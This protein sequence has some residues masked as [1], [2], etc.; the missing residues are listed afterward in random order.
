MKNTKSLVFV[1]FVLVF[2]LACGLSG[3]NLPTPAASVEPVAQPSDTPAP[4]STE[5][6][7]SPQSPESS[8]PTAP[9][10]NVPDEPVAVVHLL[11][12][13]DFSNDGVPNYDVE[14]NGTA[15]EKRAPFGDSY[16]MNLLERPFTND[17]TYIPELD[18][19][20][21]RATADET[22][23]Y[24]TIELIG[25][26]LN[27]ALGIHYGVVLDTDRNGYGDFLL[28]T[29]PPYAR[30]WTAVNVQVF[31]DLNGDSAGLS[32]LKSD[33]PFQ[34]DGY[35]TLIFDINQGIGDDADLAWVRQSGDGNLIQFAFKKELTGSQF[36]FSAIADAGLRDPGRMD[37]VDHMTEKEAGSPVRANANYPLK[38]LF[39]VDNTCQAAFGFVPTGF[40]PKGCPRIVPPTQQSSSGSGAEAT[41]GMSGCQP[42]PGGCTGDAP[43]WWP[44]PHCACSS[45]PYNP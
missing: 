17:M 8:L 44:D 43:H 16:N 25:N 20:V 42:P 5:S 33:A 28:W 30:D 37:Y 6:P 41:P 24:I 15:P 40:E 35:E 19:R 34:G 45:I 10:S 21:F 22:W 4:V 27:R 12:P 14:S 23:H 39:A 1:A 18:I 29:S 36:F 31:A 13:N 7:E 38:E 3:G 2:T 32:P 26:N 11:F 9:P